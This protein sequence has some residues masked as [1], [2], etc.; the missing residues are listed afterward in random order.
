[1][2]KVP[3]NAEPKPEPEPERFAVGSLVLLTGLQ[4]RIELNGSV[5]TIVVF[6]EDRGRYQVSV[7]DTTYLLA[8]ANLVAHELSDD[9]DEDS[10]PLSLVPDEDSDEEQESDDELLAALALSLEDPEQADQESPPP[11][12]PTDV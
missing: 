7:G 11:S 2:C 12:P 4:N 10:E 6:V 9:S 1:V 5:G 3:V 8:P